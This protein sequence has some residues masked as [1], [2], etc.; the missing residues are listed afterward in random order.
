VNTIDSLKQQAA[1]RALDE[2]ASD[3]AIGLGTGSTARFVVEGLAARLADGRLRGIVAVPTSEDTAAQARRLGIPLVTLDERP[4]LALTI[5]GADQIDPQLN[6]VKGLG[7][8]LLREKIVATASARLVVV[9]DDSKLVPALGPRTPLP[10]EIVPFAR[11]LCERR[12]RAIGLA[13]TLRLGQGGAPFVTDEGHQLLDCASGPI[14]DPWALSRAILDIP[15][16]VE[17]GMFLGLASLAVVA[18]P[19]GVRVL[20]ARQ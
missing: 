18:A 15:G 7:G 13:P 16:V 3:T 9:A 14:A 6:L 12:L 19:G 5:D 4:E 1:E 2:V 10:V 11:A 20:A 8:A 17:H